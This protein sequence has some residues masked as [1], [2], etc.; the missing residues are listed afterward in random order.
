MALTRRQKYF[1]TNFEDRPG[2]AVASLNRFEERDLRTLAGIVRGPGHYATPSPARVE[3]LVQN[4]LATKERG[5]LL[6]ATIKG[7][8]VAWFY[9]RR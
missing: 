1:A 3:R 7:R 4:G 8:I 2:A 5:G 6:R 9:R